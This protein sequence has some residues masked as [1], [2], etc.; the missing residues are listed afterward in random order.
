MLEF[1]KLKMENNDKK[2][3]KKYYKAT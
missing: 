1:T 2:K 3:M